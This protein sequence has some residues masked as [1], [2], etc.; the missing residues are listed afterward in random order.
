M[1][2]EDMDPEQYAQYRETKIHEQPGFAYNTYLCTIPLD[3]ERVALHWHDQMEI[4]YIKKGSGTVSVNL[5][6]MPVSAG[7]IIP[8]L[9]GEMHGIEGTPGIRME[10]ENII[11]SLSILDSAEEND[12]CRLH[13]IAPLMNGTMTFPRPIHPGTVFHAQVS[14]AVDRA[15]KACSERQDGYFLLVKSAMY[16]LLFQL[17]QNR[18]TDVIPQNTKHMESLKSLLGWIKQHYTESITVDQAASFA[19]YSPAHF[20]RLFKEETGQTFVQFLND[21]RL[22]SASYRLAETG[23]P[24]SEVAACCGFTNFSYFIRLFR[25]KFNVS[26]GEY[27]KKIKE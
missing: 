24:I 3:F 16:E 7:C 18:S 20:M 15:D 1:K 11:F 12:W 19:G 22:A 4:I 17:Y 2:R 27:R 14:S 10:Y 5:Q 8:V 25:K 23:D 26:P 6:S 9:P 21:Y 13:V